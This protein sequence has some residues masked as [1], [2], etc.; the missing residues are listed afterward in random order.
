M[1]ILFVVAHPDDEAYGPYGTMVNLS[2]EGHNV[3]IFCLCNGAR[4]GYEDVAPLRLK[5]FEE[6]CY[7]AGVKTLI[8]NNADL[9]LTAQQTVKEIEDVVKQ[10]APS[11]IYTHNISDINNDH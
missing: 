8:S 1:N 4:P 11:I 2:R 5:A 9:S 3:S 6:N 10:F 7:N